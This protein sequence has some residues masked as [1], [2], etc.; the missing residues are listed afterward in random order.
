MQ[1]CHNKNL[2]LFFGILISILVLI[3]PFRYI[4]NGWL[5]LI[6]LNFRYFEIIIAA[7]IVTLILAKNKTVNRSYAMF[8][9]SFIIMYCI[10]MSNYNIQSEYLST[11]L[12]FSFL[13]FS[14][15]PI[16]IF[17]FRSYANNVTLLSVLRY[18]MYGFLILSFIRFYAYF[19]SYGFISFQHVRDH[20]SL[21]HSANEII[22]LDILGIDSIPMSRLCGLVILI[23]IFFNYGSKL[24]RLLVVVAAVVLMIFAMSRQSMIAVLLVVLFM[25]SPK[26]KFLAI[27][28]VLIAVSLIWISVGIDNTR[29]LKFGR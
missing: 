10:I 12:I 28:F 25:S 15:V 19:S 4:S 5:T 26:I 29:L 9:S 7:C 27:S 18:F 1:D 20:L 2:S 14:I 17:P 6:G 11:R 21:F 23:S 16:I 3:L 22:S 8:L 13:V 24:F